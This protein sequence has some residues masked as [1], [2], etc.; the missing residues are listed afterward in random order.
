M[1]VAAT[2]LLALT[3][4]KAPGSGVLILLLIS[5]AVLCAHV[6]WGHMQGSLRAMTNLRKC[7]AD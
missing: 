6:L 2:D 4:L 3:L 5:P 1:V 7:Q